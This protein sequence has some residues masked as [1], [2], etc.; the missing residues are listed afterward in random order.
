M[1]AVLL[2]KRPFKRQLLSVVGDM[3][4]MSELSGFEQTL[5]RL[6]RA[7]AD[8]VSLASKRLQVQEAERNSRFSLAALA[9]F[10]QSKEWRDEQM[11]LQFLEALSTYE[12]EKSWKQIRKQGHV[13]WFLNE[14]AYTDWITTTTSSVLHCVGT[15]GSGKSVLMANMVDDLVLHHPASFVVYF[16]CR[17]DDS[18]SLSASTMLGSITKQIMAHL[19]PNM[20]K[21]TS[22]RKMNVL[23]TDEILDVLLRVLSTSDSQAQSLF[24]VLDGIDECKEVDADIVLECLSRLLRSSVHILHVVSSSRPDVSQGVFK[25][26]PP[27]YTLSMSASGCRDQMTPYV[28]DALKKRLPI[29]NPEIIRKI[30]DT[31]LDN[32]QGM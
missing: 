19:R 27:D 30:Q 17:Y 8:E 13:D 11:K 5:G 4:I 7:V 28:E 9:S 24:I 15:L 26:L 3:T 16:F 10:S 21:I 1:Q 29:D 25:A 31:L 20:S 2:L 32:A 22:R 23:G 18:Q 12:H 6:A 14:Q